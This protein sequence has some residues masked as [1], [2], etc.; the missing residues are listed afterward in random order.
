MRNIYNTLLF[1][2]NVCVEN[3]LM[4]LYDVHILLNIQKF[5]LPV[6]IHLRICVCFFYNIGLEIYSE[7]LNLPC[8]QLNSN[9]R[10]DADETIFNAK[11]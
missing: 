1:L 8:I 7:P 11:Y 5:R 9:V 3:T 6:Q 4:Y 2:T 10:S